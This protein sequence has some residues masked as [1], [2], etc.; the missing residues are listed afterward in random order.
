MRIIFILLFLFTTIYSQG[1][2]EDNKYFSL[3]SHYN[4]AH[5]PNYYNHKG[6]TRWGIKY[7]K[8]YDDHFAINLL[9]VKS[10]KRYAYS[11]GFAYESFSFSSDTAI[12]FVNCGSG[13]EEQKY[14]KY[15]SGNYL[16]IYSG[17]EF[18][19]FKKSS[20]LSLSTGLTLGY[21]ENAKSYDHVI[22]G[23]YLVSQISRI[24]EYKRSFFVGVAGSINGYIRMNNSF[25]F[26]PSIR[27]QFRINKLN[28]AVLGFG[29]GI[30]YKLK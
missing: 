1:K 3:H 20:Y 14:T 29:I 18:F 16:G 28:H 12:G 4:F 6:F 11:T 21:S 13:N 9:Y 2:L 5:I 7:N 25:D 30:R 17:F 27:Y 26:L 23:C 24:I 19:P 8:Y 10:K 15:G 22:E